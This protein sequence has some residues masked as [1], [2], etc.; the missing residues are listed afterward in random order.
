MTLFT[1]PNETFMWRTA[2]L[3]N[4]HWI[5]V[6]AKVTALSSKFYNNN[7][8]DVHWT[9]GEDCSV[10]PT[11]KQEALILSTERCVKGININN[12]LSLL[13]MYPTT[14]MKTLQTLCE[15]PLSPA[16]I[17]AIETCKRCNM[18]CCVV[19]HPLLHTLTVTHIYCRCRVRVC[20]HWC[21]CACRTIARRTSMHAQ[22]WQAQR[23]PLLIWLPCL[24]HEGM[25]MIYGSLQWQMTKRRRDVVIQPSPLSFPCSRSPEVSCVV[26][27]LLCPRL[28]GSSFWSS[29]KYNAHFY[30]CHSR[31][32]L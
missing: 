7:C 4:L 11:L 15:C 2:A 29:F 27:N 13:L 18:L 28:P 10:Y 32:D 5:N 12:F 22:C 20:S 24:R 3:G 25:T 8:G 1:F 31:W 30:I 6:A 9:C 19:Q 16:C 21:H 14:L 26:S 17:D 23:N